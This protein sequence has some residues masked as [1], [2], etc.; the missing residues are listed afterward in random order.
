MFSSSAPPTK[1]TVPL[2]WEAPLS[3]RCTPVPEALYV[4]SCGL[5]N[6]AAPVT[7]TAP[8]PS[9]VPFSVRFGVVIVTPDGTVIVPSTWKVPVLV[10]L[11]VLVKV[12]EPV[13]SIRPAPVRFV[14]DP[15]DRVPP[16]SSVA[17]DA[18]VNVPVSA[19]AVVPPP[20]V[21]VPTLTVTAPAF[22]AGTPTSAEAELELPVYDT[23]PAES[24]TSSF[25]L[26]P[27]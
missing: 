19:V 22:D 8:G 5:A 16:R 25:P 9:R 11:P 2:T 17:P 13:R 24:F 23:D 1:Y 27:S 18:E 3:V 12:V 15:S 10:R 26:S 4:P 6:V 20:N 7:V 14:P 21:S